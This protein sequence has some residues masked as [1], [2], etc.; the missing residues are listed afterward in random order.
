MGTTVG[1]GV[2]VLAGVAAHS[3]AG[4][5]SSVSYLLAGA[6]ASLSGLPYAELAAAFPLGK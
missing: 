5:A 1:S 2:F 3:Y 6:V 4:P